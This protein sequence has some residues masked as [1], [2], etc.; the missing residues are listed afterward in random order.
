MTPGR[1]YFFGVKKV[2]GGKR[3]TK[4]KTLERYIEILEG[5]CQENLKLVAKLAQF[6]EKV[7]S[8]ILVGERQ[9]NENETLKETLQGEEKIR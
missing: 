4:I 8:K 6:G 5:E 9:T 1:S 2:Y 3:R 7:I